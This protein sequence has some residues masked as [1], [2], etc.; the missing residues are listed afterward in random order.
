MTNCSSIRDPFWK[1]P[2]RTSK[3]GGT[4]CTTCEKR[5]NC[6]ECCSCVL[7]YICV[8][9][10][11]SCG[12]II[13]LHGNPT[14]KSAQWD[15]INHRYDLSIECDGYE[16]DIFLTYEK[17]NNIC[18]AVLTSEA[19][20]LIDDSRIKIQFTEKS[21]CKCPVWDFQIDYDSNIQIKP[22]E[23][24]SLGNQRC[25]N[26]GPDDCT[27]GRCVPRHLCAD[28][29]TTARPTKPYKTT[30][31]WYENDQIEI[32]GCCNGNKLPDILIARFTNFSDDCTCI[33]PQKSDTIYW[34]AKHMGNLFTDAGAIV[35]LKHKL[36]SDYDYYVNNYPNIPVGTNVWESYGYSTLENTYG[37]L[38]QICP[39]IP[40]LT[41]QTEDPNGYTI[42]IVYGRMLIWHD[43]VNKK[44]MVIT[45]IIDV[46]ESINNENYDY[47]DKPYDQSNPYSNVHL[48]EVDTISC[49]PFHVK[50]KQFNEPNHCYDN[51][52]NKTDGN[53][54]LQIHV[55]EFV[56]WVGQNPIDRYKKIT[57]YSE[58]V[59]VA[60]PIQNSPDCTA[61]L[62]IQELNDF[63][64]FKNR[65]DSYQVGREWPAYAYNSRFNFSQYTGTCNNENITAIDIY[66]RPC[67]G[68]PD[69]E[70][71][72][73]YATDVQTDC[74]PNR[75]PKVLTATFVSTQNCAGADGDTFELI[76]NPN[77]N[78][79]DSYEW[80]GR[81]SNG[82]C[83]FCIRLECGGLIG[84][85]PAWRFYI[86]INC[87]T[88]QLIS[89]TSTVCDP[90]LLQTAIFSPPSCICN[91]VGT[92]NQQAY[93]IISE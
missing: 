19:L 86:S 63:D 30:L 47:I 57:F 45:E 84:Q 89:T 73:P 64:S 37:D 87:T 16:L 41:N 40:C 72:D 68:C 93:I 49:N 24:V 83:D 26:K 6:H 60:A 28:V 22:Y 54:I 4:K 88:Y 7:E 42:P 23:M 70:V 8:T 34:P 90:F 56:G 76:W 71:E 61:K 13:L 50:T 51:N 35:H 17:I 10:N 12:E 78:N 80:D 48:L 33:A 81:Y 74:C 31:S 91:P 85:L 11:L 59:V 14:L 67:G 2:I 43:D 65:M 79:P 92:P 53:S 82:V 20:G 3:G 46:T 44:W 29:Y 62:H 25:I 55:Q 38:T 18:Y 52:G 27:Y 58:V 36:S 32:D 75:I 39:K 77:P 15:C 5:E 9:Y 1:Y 69:E 21:N 66:A